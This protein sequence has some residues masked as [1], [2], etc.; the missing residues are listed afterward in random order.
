[1]NATTIKSTIRSCVGVSN[2]APTS[3]YIVCVLGSEGWAWCAQDLYW[4]GH[5]ISTS[6]LRRLALQAPLM[7]KTHN[8][9]YK[10]AREGREVDKSLYRLAVGL[11]PPG[12]RRRSSSCSSVCLGFVLVGACPSKLGIV[13]STPC[14]GANPSLL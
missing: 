6:N 2:L 10:W 9:S 13:S 3:K 8:R 4:F 5:N 1:M 14:L 7:I 12:P 11:Q